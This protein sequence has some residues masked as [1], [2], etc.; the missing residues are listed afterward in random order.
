MNDFV[1][2]YI[3][4]KYKPFIFAYIDNYKIIID[5]TNKKS[6]IFNNKTPENIDTEI[7]IINNIN[8]LINN[9]I[10]N[11]PKCKK[12][13]GITYEKG[14]F[15]YSCHDYV[16]YISGFYALEDSEGYLDAKS[17]NLKLDT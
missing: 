4:F 7:E 16:K 1:V 14:K 17:K 3:N 15:H 12:Q 10:R 5:I 2:N 9:N 8:K 6:D 13:L 11:I